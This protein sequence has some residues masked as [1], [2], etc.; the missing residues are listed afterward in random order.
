[1]ALFIPSPTACVL[2]LVYSMT[3]GLS[4]IDLQNGII[5][6]SD[7]IPVAVECICTVNTHLSSQDFIQI[8]EIVRIS[9]EMLFSEEIVAIDY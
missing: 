4:G 5:I 1:M 3:M 6:D 7:T 9:E 8:R 2:V